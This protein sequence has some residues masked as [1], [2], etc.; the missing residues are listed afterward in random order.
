MWR[1]PAE[2][3]VCDRNPTRLQCREARDEAR[4][5]LSPIQSIAVCSNPSSWMTEQMDLIPFGLRYRGYKGSWPEAIAKASRC[6]AH[7][8]DCRPPSPE[9]YCCR[10]A[11]H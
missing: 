4:V 10:A 3:A 11:I 1:Y 5:D 8:R 9:K 6:T 2:G 7:E